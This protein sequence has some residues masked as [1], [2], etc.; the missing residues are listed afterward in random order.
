MRDWGGASSVKGGDVFTVQTAAGPEREE[1]TAAAKG[2]SS[3]RAE[4][5]TRRAGGVRRSSL[6]VVDRGD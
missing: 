5:K 2:G 3:E 4:S 1:R 6:R